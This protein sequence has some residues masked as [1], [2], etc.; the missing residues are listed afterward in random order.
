MLYGRDIVE[1][2]G[3]N[4]SA[5]QLNDPA[6]LLAVFREARDTGFAV[7][8]LKPEIAEADLAR[9]PV[10]SRRFAAELS[11]LGMHMAID[12]FTARQPLL[13]DGFPVDAIK[14]DASAVAQIG[15]PDGGKLLQAVL[16][17]ARKSGA[18]VI[19]EG[20]ETAAQRDFLRNSGCEFGQGYLLAEP[21]EGAALG[22]YAL[23]SAAGAD[24]S[25]NR[26]SADR[27]RAG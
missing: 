23:T 9:E 2:V 26:T 11:A 15:G 17:I 24:P 16:D 14:I 6:P 25:V 13:K 7:H 21:M 19:A 4:L 22:A 5:R 1:W 8:R 10:A 3:V 12:D 27:L 18:A 20:V